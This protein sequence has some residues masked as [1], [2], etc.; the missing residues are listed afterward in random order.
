MKLDSEDRKSSKEIS[1]ALEK[2]VEVIEHTVTY[3][4]GSK[5][6]G[7]DTLKKK[8]KVD[9]SDIFMR[10]WSKKSV[11][12]TLREVKEDGLKSDS[13]RQSLEFYSWHNPRS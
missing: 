8:K 7:T 5:T 10:S 13:G 2:M 9:S 3:K 6:R 11:R 1:S 12:R 4:E